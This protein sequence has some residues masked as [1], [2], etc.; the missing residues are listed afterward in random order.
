MPLIWSRDISPNGVVAFDPN[1]GDR[2]HRFVDFGDS[3]H[4]S[5]VIKPCVVMQRVTSNEQPRRLVAATL[6][7]HFFENY[8]GFVGENHLVIL[9]PVTTS[10]VFTPEELVVLLS[11]GSVD[12]IF[13]CISGATNVSAFELLQLALPDPARLRSLLS[14]G[15]TME[16]A[17]EISYGLIR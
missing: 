16:N 11:S 4:R 13:R 6:P 9:E 15:E 8:G 7:H 17:V 10:P 12:R 2:G 3:R 1:C 14:Q 5:V